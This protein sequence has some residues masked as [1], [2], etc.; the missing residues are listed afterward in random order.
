[1]WYCRKILESSEE[2]ILIRKWDGGTVPYV[3][4]RDR[5]GKRHSDLKYLPRSKQRIALRRTDGKCH[6]LQPEPAAA[7]VKLTKMFLDIPESL[8]YCCVPK[9]R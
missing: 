9:G 7:R 3:V 6:L 4:N 5:L 2:E 1:M 8:W